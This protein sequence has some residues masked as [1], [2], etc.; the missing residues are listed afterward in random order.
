M[1]YTEQ[2]LQDA[3]SKYHRGDGSIRSISRE[4][5]IPRT[6]LRHRING[7]QSYSIAFEPHQT[8]SLA[9]EEE[10]TQ[11]ILTQSALGVPPTH[12]QIKEFASRIILQAQGASRTT[13]GK[14]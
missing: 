8:L 7:R 9:Q 11:W 4:F 5:D 3:L 14:R 10:L 1:G 6:T 12:A 13:I 2:D